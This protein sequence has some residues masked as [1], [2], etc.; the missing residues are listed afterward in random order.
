[1]TRHFT[2]RSGALAVA[3]A[4]ICCASLPTLSF[5]FQLQVRASIHASTRG[6]RAAA[7]FTMAA[8]MGDAGSSGRQER[9]LVSTSKR[10]GSGVSAKSEIA[11]LVLSVL[12]LGGSGAPQAASAVANADLTRPV[13]GSTQE[14]L[15]ADLETRLFSL[16]PETKPAPGETAGSAD[17]ASAPAPPVEKV[18]PFNVEVETAAAVPEEQ[19]FVSQAL[20]IKPSTAPPAG[21]KSQGPPAQQPAQPL[22]TF[23]ERT[24]SITLPELNLPAAPSVA[25][26]TVPETGLR[27]SEMRVEEAPG[28]STLRE[29][30]RQTAG[31]LEKGTELLRSI[32]G[33]APKQADFER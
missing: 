6:R 1:M 23:Q 19:S 10:T 21:L 2:A 15:I 3:T 8:D 18:S 5:A 12:V 11:A 17:T 22:V 26:I 31:K 27:L 29:A 24:F 32:V 16:S 28:A 30:F 4:S 33:M 14:Q 25:P 9:R 20:S 7:C 13:D